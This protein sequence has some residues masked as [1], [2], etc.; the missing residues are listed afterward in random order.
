[1]KKLI[2]IRS[3]PIVIIILG[4]FALTLSSCFGEKYE[5][6][7]PKINSPEE[8][9][10]SCAQN[11]GLDEKDK[12]QLATIL[13][14]NGSKLNDEFKLYAMMIVTESDGVAPEDRD[15]VQKSYF[16]CL[17]NSENTKMPK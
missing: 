3:A 9:S 5:I 13:K 12:E 2:I 14:N 11:L 17:E 10:N 16:S 4:L 6:K 1:M 8:V 7:S 15:S